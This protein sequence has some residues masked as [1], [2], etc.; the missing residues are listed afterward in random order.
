MVTTAVPII[1]SELFPQQ[2]ECLT[3]LGA[4]ALGALALAL[5]LALLGDVCWVGRD[6]RVGRDGW[7]GGRSGGGLGRWVSRDGRSR[8][9][10]LGA[11]A[12]GALGALALG[13]L[14]ALG[15]LGGALAGL[16]GLAGL[17]LGRL[18]KSDSSGRLF[19]RDNK[20]IKS[21][22]ERRVSDTEYCTTTAKP[23]KR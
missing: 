17:R 2:V 3:A 13:A 14:G 15:R 1:E 16:A 22:R 19:L 5:L 4:L 6:G 20:Q 23:A 10:L 9:C 11:L 18:Q 21:K 12:L 8:G 7:F